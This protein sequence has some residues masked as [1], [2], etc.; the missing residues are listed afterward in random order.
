MICHCQSLF[1]VIVLQLFPWVMPI[2][3][4]LFMLFLHSYKARGPIPKAF[5]L[6][7]DQ[8]QLK[9]Q[10]FSFFSYHPIKWNC[11]Y[12]VVR[13]CQQKSQ[14]SHLQQQQTGKQTKVVISTLRT[15]QLSSFPPCFC[16][17]LRQKTVMGKAHCS[18]S[19]V[20]KQFQ[21]S[22]KGNAKNFQD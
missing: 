19:Q 3:Q 12:R 16:L 14:G 21:R 18:P 8:C 17:Q 2:L 22:P 13:E 7:R 20:R 11:Q 15:L 9:Q 10:S 5:Y 1:Y 6:K 4:L